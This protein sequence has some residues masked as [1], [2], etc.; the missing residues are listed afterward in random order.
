MFDISN[1][2][3]KKDSLAGEVAVITG[4]TSNVGKGFAQAGVGNIK[5]GNYL[6][7]IYHMIK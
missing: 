1:T 5:H 7:M 4:S 2:C 3:L 6:L